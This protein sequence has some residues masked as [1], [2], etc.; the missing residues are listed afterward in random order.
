M[1]SFG[2][3]S[4]DLGEVSGSSAGSL[5]WMVMAGYHLRNWTLNLQAGSNSFLGCPTVPISAVR[6]SCVATSVSGGGGTGACNGSLPL[7]TTPQQIAGGAQGDGVRSY[8]VTLNFTLAESW[9][10]VANS[11]CTITITYTVNTP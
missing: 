1:I 9:R 2:A 8:L 7:S 11:A 6:V 10:Y 4:P 3:S 5:G